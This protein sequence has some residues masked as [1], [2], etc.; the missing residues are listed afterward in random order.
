MIYQYICL[1][2]NKKACGSCRMWYHLIFSTLPVP[3]PI[4]ANS[5]Q[6]AEAKSTGLH[7]PLNMVI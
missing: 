5:G 7:D 4:L 1:F 3:E 6:D 2:I